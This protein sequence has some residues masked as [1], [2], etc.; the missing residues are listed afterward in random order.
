MPAPQAKPGEALPQVARRPSPEER[1]RIRTALDGCF[2]DARGMFLLGMSDE[3]I[4]EEAGVPAVWVS[5]I[6]E[7]AYGPVRVDAET[8]DLLRQ[9]GERLAGLEEARASID[10]FKAETEQRVAALLRGYDAQRA[11]VEALQSKVDSKFQPE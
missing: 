6:R 10:S 4:A 1:L 11:A 9:L 3:R 2:D 5:D 7:A 8:L